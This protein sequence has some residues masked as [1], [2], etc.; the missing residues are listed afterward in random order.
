MPL[1]PS[2]LSSGERGWGEG[3]STTTLRH[4]RGFKRQSVC[5]MRL[6]VFHPRTAVEEIASVEYRCPRHILVDSF[7]QRSVSL[8]AIIPR[9]DGRRSRFLLIQRLIAEA[10]SIVCCFTL[11]QWLVEIR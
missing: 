2:P 7:F 5:G 9:R 3:V 1:S 11:Q 6:E 8:P 4:T 10:A